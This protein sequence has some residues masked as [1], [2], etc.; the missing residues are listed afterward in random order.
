[1]FAKLDEATAEEATAEEATAEELLDE[2]AGTRGFCLAGAGA[3]AGAGAVPTGFAFFPNI[4]LTPV[5]IGDGKTSV[6]C[7]GNAF[8]SSG[9]SFCRVLGFSLTA[10][11]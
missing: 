10:G 3:G 11:I 4:A 7:S 1:V 6:S 8:N 2:A 9:T 5:V